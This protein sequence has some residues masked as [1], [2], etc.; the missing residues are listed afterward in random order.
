MTDIRTYKPTTIP[1]AVN[2]EKLQAE[3]AELGNVGVSMMADGLV[4]SVYDEAIEDSAIQA[5]IDVHD[6]SVKTTG[7]LFADEDNIIDR[8]NKRFVIEVIKSDPDWDSAH[9]DISKMIADNPSFVNALNNLVALQGG[10]VG[11]KHRAEQELLTFVQVIS[12]WNT[13]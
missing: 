13:I 11:D 4:F 9:A 1:D 3:V 8:V 10:D 7:Q 6:A 5:V 2:Q 12:L